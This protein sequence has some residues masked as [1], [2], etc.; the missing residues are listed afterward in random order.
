MESFLN[1]FELVS[2][3]H[4]IWIDKYPIDILIDYRPNKPA[5][6]IWK[7]NTR[8][9]N[10]VQ[11]PVFVGFSMIRANDATR[12]S[13]SDPTMYFDDKLGL[14]WYTGDVRYNFQKIISQ[15]VMYLGR[16]L[17]TKIIHTGGSGGG[18]AALYFS[19]FNVGS[20]AIPFNPQ[21][22]ILRYEEKAVKYY[23]KCLNDEI[24]EIEQARKY[25]AGHIT[26]DLTD[27]Y[28]RSNSRNYVLY[29]QNIND[30]HVDL[31]MKYLL[32][33]LNQEILGENLL[34]LHTYFTDNL[35]IYISDKWGGEH[36]PPPSEFLKQMFVDILNDQRDVLDIISDSQLFLK[37]DELQ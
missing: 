34:G 4:T 7:G 14:A 28:S 22:D 20:L 23:L 26:H 12:I 11:L 18:F 19:K 21:I 5:V 24:L 6:F 30:V 31:H 9:S 16:K 35:V 2:A 10:K 33:S 13:I 27:I 1:D 25:L 36:E 32:R 17:N 3:I 15:I 37:L 8:R 29:L